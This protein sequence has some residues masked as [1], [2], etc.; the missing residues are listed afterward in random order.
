MSHFPSLNIF[1]GSSVVLDSQLGTDCM[2]IDG[3]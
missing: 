1:S 2:Y 3:K